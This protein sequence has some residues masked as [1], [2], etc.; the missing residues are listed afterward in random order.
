MKRRE[1][2]LSKPAGTRAREKFCFALGKLAEFMNLKL[3]FD[4]KAL[5]GKHNTRQVLPRDL[6][7]DSEI[8]AWYA[9]IPNP[10]WKWIYAAIAVFGLRPHEAFFLTWE[11]D[12]QGELRFRVLEGKTGPRRVWPLYPEWV[13]K[14][15]ILDRVLPEVSLEKLHTYL[16]E[17]T[18]HMLA[19][20]GFPWPPC[21]LRHCYAGRGFE[22]GLPPN[23]MAKSMGHSLEVHMRIYRAWLQDSAYDRVFDQKM[24]NR[25][26]DSLNT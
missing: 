22:L 18:C 16:G 3:D 10:G 9:K 23:F 7:S 25:N 5:K 8:E 19:K 26:E 12:K 13:E 21:N 15:A 6:P 2:R 17:R 1:S 14:F 11:R 20:Y 24:Q 4:L